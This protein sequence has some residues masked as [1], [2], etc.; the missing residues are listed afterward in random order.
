NNLVIESDTGLSESTVQTALEIEVDALKK[1]G[2][3]HEALIRITRARETKDSW[4]IIGA[5]KDLEK[6]GLT[7][8]DIDISE[9]EFTLLTA[10]CYKHEAQQFFAWMH[11][12]DSEIWITKTRES[13]RKGGLTLA[14]IG[15]NEEKFARLAKEIYK[16]KALEALEHARKRNGD[17]QWVKWTLE[18][19]EKGELTVADIDTSVEELATLAKN[20]CKREALKSLDEARETKDV[21][22]I[23]S[24]YNHL[25]EC[26]LTLDDIDVDVNILTL[27]YGIS[28]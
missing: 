12:K 21:F 25:E 5:L 2:Y 10:E 7:L 8:A 11:E 16:H 14:D 24:M 4:Y 3:K 20:G 9:E 28:T 13:L 6:G 18:S 26:N 27:G 15:T 17:V 22:W 19:I 1:E 23:E